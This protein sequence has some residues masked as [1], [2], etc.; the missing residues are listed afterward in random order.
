MSIN[1]SQF[2]IKVIYCEIYNIQQYTVHLI[3]DH[4]FSVYIS[5]IRARKI[6]I[7]FLIKFLIYCVKLASSP[8]NPA[9]AAPNNEAMMAMPVAD[10]STAAPPAPSTAP[11]PAA[12]KGAANPP[13]TPDQNTHDH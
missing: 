3:C 7:H 5:Y 10:P 1:N 12:T 13:V 11:A 4:S 8:V 6:I 9:P 2:I